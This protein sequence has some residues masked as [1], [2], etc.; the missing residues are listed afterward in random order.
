MGD[1][2]SP[3]ADLP[4]KETVSAP[5]A[6]SVDADD[7][8]TPE[9]DQPRDNKDIEAQI[10]DHILPRLDPDFLAYYVAVQLRLGAPQQGQRPVTNPTIEHVRAHPEAYQ[11]PCAIDTSSHPRVADSC[12]QSQDGASIRA[13]VYHPDPAEHG[14]GPYPA[15]LNFHG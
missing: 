14:D 3:N 10:E 8:K 13:R 9:T 6:A 4:E 15:H 2:D 5:E 12:Y 7:T 11:P 1:P